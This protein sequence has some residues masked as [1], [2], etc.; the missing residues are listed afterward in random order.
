MTASFRKIDYSL[1]PAKHAERRMLCEVFRRLSGFQPVEDYIYV[2]LGSLWFSDFI[3]FHRSLGIRNMISIDRSGNK[4]RFSANRPFNSVTLDLSETSK[5]LPRLNW[6]Q[7]QF[8]WLDYDDQID[9]DKVL[10]A[11]TV[12]SRASSGSL[13]AVSVQCEMAKEYIAFQTEGPPSSLDRFRT[14]FGSERVAQDIEEDDL[15]SWRFGALSRTLLLNEIE[16]ALA[17]R[18]GGVAERDR[19]RF[20]PVCDIN[21]SDGAKMTTLV[22]IFVANHELELLGKCNLDRLDFLPKNKGNR[23]VNIHVP[24][25]TVREIRTLEQQIPKG[26]ESWNVPGVPSK[27]ADAFAALYRYLPNFGILEC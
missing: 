3:L 21:Y 8:I 5:A 2:G 25:L 19:I 27:D 17:T 14:Q 24:K 7:R 15:V 18:N 6:T 13:F 16:S 22:G 12:A 4:K 10:D 1:R 26:P 11:R 9:L 23:L 20:Q